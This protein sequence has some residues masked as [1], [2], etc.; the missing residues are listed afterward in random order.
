MDQITRAWKNPLFRASLSAEEL[1]ALPDHPAGVIE[2]ADHRL[3]NVVGGGITDT[4]V[5]CGHKTCRTCFTCDW[6][7]A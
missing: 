4:W 6:L 5:T 3:D 7:C 1:S 2:I